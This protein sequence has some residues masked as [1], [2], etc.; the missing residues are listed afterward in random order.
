MV[1][2]GSVCAAVALA[3][4]C[5]TLNDSVEHKLKAYPRNACNRKGAPNRLWRKAV[6]FVSDVA[7]HIAATNSFYLGSAHFA[8][9]VSTPNTKLAPLTQATISY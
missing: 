7:M 5:T 6:L 3:R 9:A 2:D 8:T 4:L 1:L